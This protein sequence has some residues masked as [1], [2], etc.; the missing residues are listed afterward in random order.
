MNNLY[1]LAD[2]LKPLG[3]ALVDEGIQKYFKSLDSIING[4]RV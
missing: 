2:V 3:H 4:I 1:E